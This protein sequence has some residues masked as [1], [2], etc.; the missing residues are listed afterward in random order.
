MKAASITNFF[1]SG[2]KK[3][4][5]HFLSVILS[6]GHQRETLLHMLK[7]WGP[8]SSLLY[9]NGKVADINTANLVS[10]LSLSIYV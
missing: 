9:H 5:E 1:F 6:V 7:C 4:L 10:L 8:S 3:A 2:K